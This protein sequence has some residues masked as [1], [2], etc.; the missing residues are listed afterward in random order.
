MSPHMEARLL[1]RQIADLYVLFPELEEDDE[2]RRDVLEGETNLDAILS[3]IVAKIRESAAFVDALKAQKDQLS[4]R[5]ERFKRR[6]EAMRSLA[7]RLMDAAKTRK[8]E[9][10][11]ATLSIRATP[12]SVQIT[13]E[14]AVPDAYTKT[15][16]HIDKTAV[17]DALKAG[18]PVPGAVL[19]NGGDTLS[20]RMT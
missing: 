7:F 5:Q 8:M 6:G 18:E 2:L 20:V 4:E 15:V 19:T 17:K 9:L 1:E 11:E 14:N 16:R 13:D 12:Q 10:P 3:R